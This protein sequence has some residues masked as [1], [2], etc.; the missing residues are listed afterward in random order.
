MFG[1]FK[2][3]LFRFVIIESK[4]TLLINKM[5]KPNHQSAQVPLSLSLTLLLWSL[6]TPPHNPLVVN[7]FCILMPMACHC[8]VLSVLT[9]LWETELK[10]ECRQELRLRAIIFFLKRQPLVH[11]INIQYQIKTKYKWNEAIKKKGY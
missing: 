4:F 1:Y 3:L 2:T 5:T 8:P 11:A 10:W 6:L 9:H 7:K